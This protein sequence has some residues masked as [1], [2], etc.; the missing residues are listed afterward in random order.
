MTLTHKFIR[1]VCNCVPSYVL[2]RAWSPGLCAVGDALVLFPLFSFFRSFCLFVS[3]FGRR[4]SAGLLPAMGGG[5][6]RFPCGFGLRQVGA[7]LFPTGVFM[8]RDLL[9]FPQPRF[10][11]SKIDVDAT[12]DC[13]EGLLLNFDDPA[14]LRSQPGKPR[15]SS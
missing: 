5:C 9:G 6:P 13:F 4:L 7:R 15:C 3:L 10:L 12:I 14:L 11:I 2:R 1:P 8:P